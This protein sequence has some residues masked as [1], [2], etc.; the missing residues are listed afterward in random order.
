MHALH[1]DGSYYWSYTVKGP[2][3]GRAEIAG[4]GAVIVPTTQ[5]IYAIRPDGTLIWSFR[6]PVRIRGDLI[7]GLGDRLYFGGEDGRVFS[8]Y[9]RGAVFGLT[10]AKVSA[11]PIALS[12]GAIAAGRADGGVLVS[13]KR[14]VERFKLDGPV[15]AVLSC[16]GARVCAIAGGVLHALGMPQGG[17]FVTPAV[18]ARQNGDLLGILSPDQRL[19]VFRGTSGERIFAVPLPEAASASPVMDGRGTTYVP[20]RNGALLG[21]AADG[22]VTACVAIGSSPL[23]EP[24]LDAPRKRLLV[25]ASE[26]VVAS[27]QLE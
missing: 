21:F 4:S 13:S 1:P 9:N 23:G 8:V 27:V 25:T 20:L 17:S 26:G 16:P 6:G 3:T 18:R 11:L 5:Q 7:R 14:R 2:V 19:E 22:G 10:R 12:D 15:T 24:V